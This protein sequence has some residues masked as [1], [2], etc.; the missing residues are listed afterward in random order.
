MILARFPDATFTVAEEDD[1]EGVY[2]TPM[3][4]IEDTS[5]VMDVILSRMVDMQVD[6]DLQ[7]YVEPVRP[8][9]RVLEELH[10]TQ[11]E[12]AEAGAGGSPAT[13]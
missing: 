10:R 5:D 12:R 11:R 3:V 2:L 7:V 4:D 1:P 9:E 8:L 6:E 13:E